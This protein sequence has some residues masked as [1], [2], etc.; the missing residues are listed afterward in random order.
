MA[1]I[2][3]QGATVV[4]LSMAKQSKLHTSWV[5]AMIALSCLLPSCSSSNS[6][7]GAGGAASSS[8]GARS[9][10]GTFGGMSNSGGGTS[11]GGTTHTGPWKIMMLGDSITAT[12]C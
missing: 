7:A 10:G 11:V 9:A 2:S 5:S 6:S 8:G 1:H 4:Q 12:T 3:Q